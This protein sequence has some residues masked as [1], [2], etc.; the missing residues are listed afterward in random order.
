MVALTADVTA[1]AVPQSA[2]ALDLAACPGRAGIQCGTRTVPPDRMGGIGGTT[3][4]RVQR[5]VALR[6]GRGAARVRNGRLTITLDRWSEVRGVTLTGTITVVGATVNGD[7][8]RVAGRG[9]H[10]ALQATS[11]CLVGFLADE[12]VALDIAGL[13]GGTGA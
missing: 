12:P 3:R 6:S 10:G 9:S 8:V 5:I 11:G 13:L 4:L 1:L 2:S 7:P